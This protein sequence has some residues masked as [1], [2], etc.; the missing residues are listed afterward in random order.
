M[1]HGQYAYYWNA[2]LLTMCPCS[3]DFYNGL[4]HGGF[5]PWRGGC[6]RKS[7]VS[8]VFYSTDRV[9]MWCSISNS[10]HFYFSIFKSQT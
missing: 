5:C 7:V 9:G 6:Q 2:F 10:L 1:G 8:Q 3:E 4:L